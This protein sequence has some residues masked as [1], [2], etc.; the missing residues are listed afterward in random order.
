MRRTAIAAALSAA[1][2]IGVG[3]VRQHRMKAEFE[4]RLAY[5]NGRID[6]LFDTVEKSVRTSR[7]L[8]KQ[9][10]DSY[11]DDVAGRQPSRVSPPNAEHGGK[12]VRL[13]NSKGDEVEVAPDGTISRVR[14][15]PA[16]IRDE[17]RACLADPKSNCRE[18]VL[19]YIMED[20]KD[21]IEEC[22]QAAKRSRP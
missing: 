11:D 19:T 9:W 21:S 3:I 20:P 12:P 16:Q 6:I 14:P 7:A 15:S 18:A 2:A 22:E 1:L 13:K 8:N 4:E 5:A 10:A 17:C